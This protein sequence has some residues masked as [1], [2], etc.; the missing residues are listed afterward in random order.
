MCQSARVE[1]NRTIVYKFSMARTKIISDDQVLAVLRHLLAAGGDKA[2]SFGSL[3]RAV[4]L[5]PSTLVQRFGTM[6]AMRAAALS[7]GWQDLIDATT[8]VLDSTSQKG[9]Q[10]LLKALDAI[11]APVPNL[12][13]S[14]ADETSRTLATQWRQMVETALA[15]RIGQGEKAGETASLLF[16]AWQGQLLWGGGGFRLKDA[17]KRLI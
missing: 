7:R 3:G 13:R 9:P 12:L 17:A 10:G 16:A 8:A 4:K 15:Q 14:T 5:A 1:T 2:V 11:A 6:A